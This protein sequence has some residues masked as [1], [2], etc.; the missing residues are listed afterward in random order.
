MHSLS[1]INFDQLLSEYSSITG[2]S[3]LINEDAAA[4]RRCAVRGVVAY[5]DRSGIHLSNFVKRQ[6]LLGQAVIVHELAHMVQLYNGTAG[7]PFDPPALLEHEATAVER[8]A[9]RSLSDIAG[10]ASPE[11]ALPLWWLIPIAAGVYSLLRPSAANAPAPADKVY[12]SVSTGQVAA[13]A[14][15]LF[16]IPGAGYA[17]SGRLGLGWISSSAIS[18][19]LATTSFRGVHDVTRGHGVPQW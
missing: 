11:S 15:A 6:T 3:C 4:S 10:K 14:L 5:A 19:S 9:L 13:E 12:P 17:I 18:G 2:R 16:A 1:V 7:G 8:G